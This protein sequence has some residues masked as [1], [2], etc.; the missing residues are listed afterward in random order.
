MPRSYYKNIQ[1]LKGCESCDI[2][3]CLTCKDNYTLN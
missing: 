3:E 1:A 2:N